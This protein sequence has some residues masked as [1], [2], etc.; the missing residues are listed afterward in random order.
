MKDEFKKGMKTSVLYG[1][2]AFITFSVII[3]MVTQLTKIYLDLTN[4]NSDLIGYIN[5]SLITLL[6]I[7]TGAYGYFT[8][9][10]V[11][12][13]RK[14]RQIAFIERKLEKLYY[15]LKDVL[16][17]PITINDVKQIAWKK[18]EE[19]AP[20]QYLAYEESKDM[21][22]EF[23]EKVI[24]SKTEYEG[25]LMFSNFENGELKTIINDDIEMYENELNELT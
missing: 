8:W 4:Y 14:S 22:N 10:I 23:I 3:L 20:F 12:D 21:I 13:Q 17:N 16:S 25:A 11:D 18:V 2:V 6:V 24:K 19:I 5:I 7:I 9:E 1:I 15:P